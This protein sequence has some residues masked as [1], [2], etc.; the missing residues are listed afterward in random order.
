MRSSW[1][2]SPPGCR[3]GNAG[4]MTEH[5]LCAETLTPAHALLTQ[6]GYTTRR[7]RGLHKA[8]TGTPETPETCWDSK[9]T[10]G[11]P[12][13]LSHHAASPLAF[14]GHSREEAAQHNDNQHHGMIQGS[15]R[16]SY[17]TTSW[18]EADLIPN[19]QTWRALS[20]CN[21]E[22]VVTLGEF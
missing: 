5:G 3:W 13:A 14:P 7:F 22:I 17:F 12:K 18:E 15:K 2:R 6:Q 8:R 1:D 19:H 11:H 10:T 21:K 20:C 16:R 4:S 9:P